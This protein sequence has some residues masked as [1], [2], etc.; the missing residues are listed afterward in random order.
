MKTNRAHNG[1]RLRTMHIS[2]LPIWDM[3]RGKGRIS[4]YL[5]LKT[6]CDRGH[7]VR[8]LTTSKNQERGK[9]GGINV[10]KLRTILPRSTRRY[11]TTLTVYLNSFLSIVQSLITSLKYKPD[12]IYAHG[13]GSAISTFIASR[14][15]NSKYIL[16]QYG[17]TYFVLGRSDYICRMIHRVLLYLPYKLPA[18]IHIVTND[19]TLGDMAAKSYGIPPD[20]LCFWVNGI[21]RDWMNGSVNDKLRQK[22]APGNEKV[23]LLLS[24]LV[25]PKQVDFLVKAIPRVVETYKS[26]TFA[27]VG[28]GSKRAYLEQLVRKLGISDFV[29]FEGAVLHEK[30]LEYMKVCDVF[31][32]MNGASSI[33]NP[34]LETMVCGKPVIALNTGA[35]SELIKHNYNG[36]LVNVD[37]IDRLPD[38]ILSLLTNEDHAKELGENAQRFMLDNW[39]TWEERTGWEADLI[40]ALC[41]NDPERVAAVKKEADTV[42][43]LGIRRSKRNRSSDS[44]ATKVREHQAQ[45]SENND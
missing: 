30:A 41:S 9:V 44:M 39:P 26:V 15:V 4:T 40:E 6:L 23:V 7:K 20:K 3:G 43:N 42:L 11:W 37:E 21:C 28:D 35:T 18:D 1:K 2:S 13:Y 14:V 32:S 8:Y 10:G 19:G 31:V 24:R 45:S 5:P 17:T 16:K 22:L 29:R 36:L 38:T 33:C 34:V 25:R 12:V 27:I